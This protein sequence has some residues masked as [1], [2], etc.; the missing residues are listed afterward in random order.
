MNNS[1]VKQIL[2]LSLV[3]LPFSGYT[4]ECVD[5]YRV[6]D[7]TMDITKS[8]KIYSQSKGF[9]MS[10][11]DSL[12]INVVLYGQKD[13]IFSF[14]THAKL[15]P[16]RFRFIDPETKQII[17]DNISDDFIESVGIG[18]DITRNLTVRINLLARKADESD[19]EDR[20]GCVGM[21]IQYKNYFAE[22]HRIQM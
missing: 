21:L 5:Y 17:Y 19:I 3:V 8:Y 22:K 18:F 11:L 1:F 15:Y 6:G 7:C 9:M 12:D 4:Q 13:Y 10:P 2:T 14:C 20:I 16:I